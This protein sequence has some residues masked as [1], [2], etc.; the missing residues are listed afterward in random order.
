MAVIFLFVLKG[1]VT[2]KIVLI[3]AGEV[4]YNVAKDLSADGHDIIIVE[5]N[6][7]RVQRVENDLDVIVIQAMEPDRAF[8]KKQG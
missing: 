6:E 8:L 3:G 1:G 5:E 4:G 7:E 2:L